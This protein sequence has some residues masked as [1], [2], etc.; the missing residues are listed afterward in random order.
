[1]VMLCTYLKATTLAH[2]PCHAIHLL[3]VHVLLFFLVQGLHKFL[4]GVS[5][6]APHAVHHPHGITFTILCQPHLLEYL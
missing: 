1:M 5:Q 3:I 6:E 2:D 4:G